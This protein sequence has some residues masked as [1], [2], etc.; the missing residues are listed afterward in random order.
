MRRVGGRQSPVR[1]CTLAPFVWCFGRRL[2]PAKRG[3]TPYPF[4][5]GAAF[6]EVLRRAGGQPGLGCV[7]ALTAM[8]GPCPT[9]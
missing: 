9:Y 4:D 2:G 6:N 8:Q 7:A 3:I 5:R 1:R